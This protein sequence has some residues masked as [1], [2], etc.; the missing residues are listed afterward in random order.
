MRRKQEATAQF[1]LS[2]KSA[3]NKIAKP[4]NK[5]KKAEEMSFMTTQRSRHQTIK[6]NS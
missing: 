3:I 6:D 4:N 5:E 2:H 1:Q